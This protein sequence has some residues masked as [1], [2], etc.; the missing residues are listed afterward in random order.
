MDRTQNYGVAG[1]ESDAD[2]VD[3][4]AS[5]FP[6]IFFLVAALVALTTMTRMVEEER[7]LIGTY[8]ALGYARCAHR[9]EVPGVRGRW[10]AWRAALLGI[11]VL[12]QVLPAVIQKAYAI[13]YFVPQVAAAH[14]PRAGGAC[15][16]LGRGRHAGGHVGRRAR[17]RCAKARRSS[18]C[19]ARRRRASASC[20]SASGPLWRRL[21]FSW[22][23]TFRNLFRY[24]KRFVMTVVGIAGCT[25]LLLTGLGL[26]DAI[27]DIIDKQFGEITKYNATVVTDED[28]DAA[29]EAAARRGARHRRR[30]V[31]DSMRIMRANMVANAGRRARCMCTTGGA[32]RTRRPWATSSLMRTRVGHVPLCSWARTAIVLAEKLANELR[33]GRGRHG[34]AVPSRT[35]WATPRARRTSWW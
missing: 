4:I 18:C 15:G 12:S 34:D 23:V 2:R 8:K 26:S 24:K 3:S 22:K 30:Y 28:L 1:F 32:R 35:R 6:F 14:R 27:N 10:P 9:L 25:A 21:S 13:I 20:W 17:R 33:R 16:R 11:A 29:D 19:R 5:V 31:S 7:V